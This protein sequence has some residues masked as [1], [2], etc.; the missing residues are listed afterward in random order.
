[1]RFKNKIIL[2]IIA[3]LV[4]L[5]LSKD[6]I[7]KLS[8]EKALKLTTGLTAKIDNF[9]IRFPV[10]NVIRIEGLKIF[11]PRSYSDRVMAEVSGVYMDYD[12]GS[13]FTNKVVLN[14]MLLDIK[15][16][17]VVISQT[18]E[19]NLA[20]LKIPK[21]ENPKDI[22]KDIKIG[23]LTLR[24]GKVI[25]KDYSSD[26]PVTKEYNLNLDEKFQKI[27]G[28]NALVRVVVVKTIASTAIHNLAGF[29]IDEMKGSVAGIL[30]GGN[31]ALSGVKKVGEALRKTKDAFQSFFSKDKTQPSK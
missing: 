14:D 15:E 7:V 30:T 11:N 21:S 12:F 1:M 23:R 27:D 18:G 17:A 13:I 19:A 4:L 26:P 24:I 5:A 20:S 3:L 22:K 16:L 25:Y 29:N 10:R 28:L 9:H 6:F 2:L 31:Q 8:V